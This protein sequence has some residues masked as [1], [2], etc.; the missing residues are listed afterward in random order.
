MLI[1]G[2]LDV[3]ET[4]LAS[5]LKASGAEL[6]GDAD[7]LKYSG[8]PH[9]FVGPIGI[10]IPILADESTLSMHDCI[11]GSGEDGFHLRHIEPGR[12][13][14][15]FMTA[16]VRTCKEGDLCLD[17]GGTFYMKKGNEL[18]HIFKLGTKY[19]KSMNVTYL[20]QNAKPVTPLMGCYGIGLDR[21]LASIIEAY[22]DDNGII[23]PMSVAPFHVAIVPVKYEGKMK[24]AA[25]S[26]YSQLTDA[27]IEVLLDDRN[28][29]PGVKFMD[30]DLIGY[31]VRVVIGEKNLPNVEVKLRNEKDAELIPLENASEKIA[32]IVLSAL[33]ELD[34]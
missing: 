27:G 8:A 12:D 1:R 15:P 14:V 29:R 28:E 24:E 2:D 21:T 30:A 23:W 18:G 20:D 19:T 9:G 25:D 4:K 5:V 3:N 34:K 31:P 22:H 32:K 7:V 11:G 6:A 33:A 10:K 26:L 16:D 17:C 13:Y